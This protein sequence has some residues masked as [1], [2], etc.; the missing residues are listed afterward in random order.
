MVFALFCV[1][2]CL[3]CS[4]FGWFAHAAYLHNFVYRPR[5]LNILHYSR[6]SLRN[7]K[8]SNTLREL[9]RKQSLVKKARGRIALDELLGRYDNF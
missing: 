8:R 3:L 4:L 6:R 1:L 5:R 7:Y 2:V 9:G